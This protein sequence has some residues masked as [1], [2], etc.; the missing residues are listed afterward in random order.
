MWSGI[1]YLSVFSDSNTYDMTTVNRTVNNDIS[2]RL[3]N[4]Q[5]AVNYVLHFYLT[6]QQQLVL[7]S[8]P[9]ISCIANEPTS[10]KYIQYIYNYI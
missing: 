2:L 4:L 1:I 3:H 7:T 9:D 5:L 8:L 10:G 6:S